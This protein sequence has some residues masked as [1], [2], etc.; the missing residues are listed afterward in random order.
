ITKA[1]HRRQFY[2]CC[3]PW[4]G[5]RAVA[6]L[7]LRP[8]LPIAKL[9]KLLGEGAQSRAVQKYDDKFENLHDM[10]GQMA[11]PQAK[12]QGEKRT[13]K[14]FREPGRSVALADATEIGN[15]ST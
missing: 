14:T 10:R 11:T 2:C 6:I 15:I 1:G 4:P 5:T 3:R 13:K 7:G 12:E 8:A 9:L